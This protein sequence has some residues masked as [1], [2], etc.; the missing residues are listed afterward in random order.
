MFYLS[1]LTDKSIKSNKGEISYELAK[2]LAHY[3]T[4][5]DLVTEEDD[6]KTVIESLNPK[7]EVIKIKVE[8]ETTNISTNMIA[9][10][11]TSK[12]GD[13]N[14]TEENKENTPK[15]NVKKDSDN[16]KDAAASA[17]AAGEDKSVDKP[18]SEK[19]KVDNDKLDAKVE[20]DGADANAKASTT[21]MSDNDDSKTLLKEVKNE[22][23]EDK[24]MTSDKTEEKEVENEKTIDEK[25]AKKEDNTKDERS[26]PL[27]LS[28]P[29]LSEEPVDHI[30]KVKSIHENSPSLRSMLG[31]ESVDKNIKRTVK[32]YVQSCETVFVVSEDM[33]SKM[34]DDKNKK[35]G[36]ISVLIQFKAIVT[37]GILK[38]KSAIEFGS[39]G[40]IS[41]TLIKFIT[42]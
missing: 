8:S 39:S 18:S 1:K 4:I 23:A 41:G 26:S 27:Q 29:K 10:I 34:A 11:K 35:N 6:D 14:V 28:T 5:D 3:N 15:E 40:V 20:T 9:D 12:D 32:Q 24:E 42:H 33:E 21:T 2:I 25:V 38:H 13:A 22:D 36:E 30:A 19:E 16:S 7:E 31:L 37:L 17:S